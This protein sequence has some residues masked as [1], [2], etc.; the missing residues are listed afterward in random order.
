MHEEFFFLDS[1]YD[2]QMNTSDTALTIYLKNVA[3]NMLRQIQ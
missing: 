1:V 3:L 2:K